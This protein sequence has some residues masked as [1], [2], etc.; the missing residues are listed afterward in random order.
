MTRVTLLLMLGFLA[1]TTLADEPVAPS[2][3]IRDHIPKPG[4]FPPPNAGIHLSGDLVYTE[5]FNR[6]GGLRN[7][8]G[9]TDPRRH[10]LR[11]LMTVDDVEQL[12]VIV[13][14]TDNEDYGVQGLVRSLV[15]SDLF[16]QR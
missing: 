10:A 1:T 7:G 3:S 8:N 9:T 4:S 6:R 14:S 12:H 5:P 11:R 15:I 16:R 13:E 2:D